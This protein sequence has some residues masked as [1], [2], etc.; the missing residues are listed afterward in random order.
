MSL[1][2]VL[3]FL[4]YF[5]FNE[6]IFFSFLILWCEKLFF[7]FF[8][9]FISSSTPLFF[10]HRWCVSECFLNFFL[11]FIVF[12]NKMRR[13]MKNVWLSNE[14]YSWEY[15][16]TCACKKKKK[17]RA[18]SHFFLI[19]SMKMWKNFMMFMSFRCVCPC[20]FE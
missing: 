3:W 2:P 18:C 8:F 16:C 7:F 4:Y 13:M 11:S 10:H 6:R 1:F 15:V 12:K 14:T 9:A 17:L 20:L 5:F 19:F